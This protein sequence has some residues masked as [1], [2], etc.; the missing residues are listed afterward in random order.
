IF[1]GVYTVPCNL[2]KDVWIELGSSDTDRSNTQGNSSTNMFKVSARDIVRERASG[3][4]G[5]FNTC[6]SG[7]QA[8]KNDDDDWILGNIWFMN[9]YMTLDHRHRRVGIAPAVR[10]R[11]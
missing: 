11:E 6:L 4:D 1:S 8:S 3:I 7:I 2:K 10:L 9:N 5:L